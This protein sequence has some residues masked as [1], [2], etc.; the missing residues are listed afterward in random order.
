MNAAFADAAERRRPLLGFF[1]RALVVPTVLFLII[2]VSTAASAFYIS[3]HT[4]RNAERLLVSSAREQA[5][6]LRATLDGQFKVLGIFASTLAADMPEE[7][8]MVRHLAIACDNSDFDTMSCIT[9]D[10]N[11]LRND[12]S[13]R[14]LPERSFFKRAMA[15]NRTIERINV[16]GRSDARFVLAVPV[17]KGGKTTGVVIGRF[18][19][20][21]LRALLMPEIYGQDA[22]SFVCDEDGEFQ[23]SSFSQNVRIRE[24]NLFKVL[25]D[26]SGKYNI[27]SPVNMIKDDMKTGRTRMMKF[28][29]PD[30]DGRHFV[31]VPLDVETSRGKEC[32]LFNVMRSE[33][34]EDEIAHEMF[35]VVALCLLILL[36][37]CAAY[38]IV[39]A[40]ERRI[41]KRIA[42]DA[43]RLRT[44]EEQ[45]RIAAFAS[46]RGVSRYDIKNGVY[47]SVS[48]SGLLEEYGFGSVIEGAPQ[49][50]V[51]CG[52]I[53]PECVRDFLEFYARLR[54]GE[55]NPSAEIALRSKG[56]EVR[57]FRVAATVTFDHEGNPSQA[58]ETFA[59]VTERRE[60]N[61]AYA[62]W[63]RSMDERDP[64]EFTLFECNLT[65]GA[66][67]DRMWG[68]LL[69]YDFDPDIKTFNGRTIE[70]ARQYVCHDDYEKYTEF[71]NS[72]LLLAGYYK[73]VSKRSLEYREIVSD[74]TLRWLRVSVETG[75][76]TDSDD[77]EIVMLYED[78]DEKKRA[79]E[80]MLRR[81]ETDELTGALNRQ[82]FTE[83]FDALVCDEPETLHALLMVDVDGFKVIND[84]FG[85][86]GGD[87]ALK[88]IAEAMRGAL[89]EGDMLARFS[90]DE[91]LVC[92]RNMPDRAAITETASR[93]CA[94][95]RR[96]L[97]FDMQ[98]SL[99]I[100]IACF[101]DDGADFAD[102]YPKADAALYYVKGSGK[103]SFAFYI[104]KMCDSFP[105]HMSEDG[106]GA[107]G[108]ESK[109]RM[110][111]VD[112]DETA[113]AMISAVFE[114]DYN[115]ITANNGRAGLVRMKNYGSLLSVVILD[116]Y[117]PELDG[118]DV[119]KQIHRRP[120][121]QFVPIVVVSSTEDPES[122]IKAIKLGAADFVYKP[123]D[124]DVL[125]LRV[126][127]AVNRAEN[128]RSRAQASGGLDDEE[129]KYRGIFED[130]GTVVV[131]FDLLNQTYSY[132]PMMSDYLA[133]SYDDRKLWQI[134]LSDM[135]AKTEDVMTMQDLVS[136]IAGTMHRRSGSAEILL[137]TPSNQ[138]H[139]FLFNVFK[140]ERGLKR[141]EKLYLTFKDIND[142]LM[143]D[144]K[145]RFQAE[146][147]AL[148]GLYSHNAFLAKM[149]AKVRPAQPGSWSLFVGDVDH[150]K[151]YNDRYGHAEGDRLLLYIAERLNSFAEACGGIC[152][153]LGSDIFALL[154][155]SGDDV[156]TALTKALK[157]L[158][159]DFRPDAGLR[160]GMGMYVI[161]RPDMPVDSMLDR[162]MLARQSIKG[163]YG[164]YISPYSDDMFASLQD[165]QE[166]TEE[167][168]AALADGQFQIFFQPQFNH[169]NGK[170]TGA[171]ALVR[172]MHP[173]KGIVPPSKFI[174][175]FEKNGFVTKLD[176]YVWNRAAEALRCWLD[177][178]RDP[179]PISVNI[180]RLDIGD[181]CLCDKLL[182]IVHRNNIPIELFRLEITESLFSEDSERMVA[183]VDQL[184]EAGFII[185]MDDFGSGY[186][187]LN[188][189]KDVPV[190]VIK[191][192]M[193]FFSGDDMRKRGDVIVRAVVSMAKWLN[194][195]VIAEGVERKEQADFLLN[196]GC[197]V[198]Q[199][200]LYARPMP[201]KEFKQLAAETGTD[202]E[203]FEEGGAE[204]R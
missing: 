200:F 164:V 125:R 48:P 34:I 174:P 84:V 53:A 184:H 180:S 62:R 187:S 144:E 127:A 56:G 24:R 141:T 3:R 88:E 185:E 83:K 134:F 128:E 59:D 5:K 74:S 76:Y 175:V 6:T 183:I 11:A 182:D 149:S 28:P 7:K 55:S 19:E 190:D 115:I 171:E 81:A 65:R 191:L 51:D 16:D 126:N 12:G 31:C 111:I 60:M 166:I 68:S 124:A 112:D 195:R 47:Y 193:R 41:A 132:D 2:V 201:V 202:P 170:I 36:S 160:G 72:D 98:V 80:S 156:L 58:I 33:I 86:D 27:P 63:K 192:D 35:A 173:K 57:W 145:L 169:E 8:E 82:A 123:L 52:V 18:N 102:L 147:D 165:E 121:M 139:W 105:E 107:A 162:A 194:A 45:F 196:V 42:D 38:Y 131:E 23:I 49:V 69:N 138:R 103:D 30:G 186:S 92:L 50:F 73:G 129:A 143:E 203:S 133:G 99:S 198:I 40:G 136:S 10:G 168:E 44:S 46:G 157:C 61:A 9:P 64:K 43:E 118:F 26:T 199:G 54:A 70:Y 151:I 130:M 163:R 178:G 176:E 66:S 114:D 90:G 109:P 161:D 158:F 188:I 4:K 94:R 152:G 142:K 197:R 13:V 87:T 179:L 32:F 91:F 140:K 113:V 77:V 110:L 177:S 100:G 135:V 101:P 14:G 17:K 167:M 146:H 154:V 116:I 22:Y 39:V 119:L 21:T 67:F 78:I 85:H 137:K 93:M 25:A 117:M 150:F 122:S 96:A 153:R 181:A 189:L 95:A 104:D 120:E 159:P 15:G 75:P 108:P 79:E 37:T 204:K 155:P 172:W 97:S 29:A 71:L 148:T 89:R 1:P 106:H 20:G